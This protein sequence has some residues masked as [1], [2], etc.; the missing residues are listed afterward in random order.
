MLPLSQAATDDIPA[1]L[2][3][4]GGEEV[5]KTVHKLCNM[6]WEEEKRPV[7]WTKSVLVMIPKKGNLTELKL[8]GRYRTDKISSS[9]CSN[10]LH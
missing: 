2:L 3:R 4:A 1:E 8:D 5:V 6:V 9:G 10:S 7:E